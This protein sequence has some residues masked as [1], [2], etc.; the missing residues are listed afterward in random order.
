MS[1]L[2][3]RRKNAT[4]ESIFMDRKKVMDALPKLCEKQDFRFRSTEVRNI[5]LVGRSRTGKSTVIRTL[6]TVENVVKPLT[7]FSETKSVHFRNFSLRGQDQM[8]YTFNIIDTPGLFEV[9][10]KEEK[11]RT[12][13]EIL[14]MISDC[15]KNE[16]TRLH[17]I[18]LFC[19]LTAGVDRT[20]VIAMKKL[21][22]TFGV[23]TNMAICVT[24]SENMSNT[25]RA[26]IVKELEEHVEM[27][28]L[29]NQVNSNIFFMGA[30]DPERVT[31][32]STL[33]KLVDKIIDDRANFLEFIFLC[34]NDTKIEDL[35]FVHAKRAEIKKKIQDNQKN[36]GL[37]LTRK[38]DDEQSLLAA[39]NCQI[40]V[41]ELRHLVSLFD[42]ECLELYAKISKDM[43][44]LALK[45]PKVDS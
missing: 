19:S 4:R 38:L 26:N 2:Q 20:D 18:I 40:E 44:D 37:Y 27:G 6:Q 36:I 15:L 9:K 42:A 30:I 21:I 25:D 33:E 29:L 45:L 28:E 17:V 34:N 16:I 41:R 35:K 22:E 24:R 11:A 7:I 13:A 43:D 10:R 31:D 23:E 14:D 8:D 32:E 5:L 3:N 12:D 39:Q 1:E